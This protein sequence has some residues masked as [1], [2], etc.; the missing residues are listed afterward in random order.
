M[1]VAD[2]EM[3]TL[4]SSLGLPDVQPFV[5]LQGVAMAE[6]IVGK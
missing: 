1:S 3:K 6:H 4:P 5:Q 2:A